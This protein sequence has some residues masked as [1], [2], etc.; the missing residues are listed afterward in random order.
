MNKQGSQNYKLCHIQFFYFLTVLYVD[1][2]ITF[3]TYLTRNKIKSLKFSQSSTMA[4]DHGIHST[5]DFF[6][7]KNAQLDI[8]YLV[9]H[10]SLNLFVW[11]SIFLPL[12]HKRKYPVLRSTCSSNA[13][14]IS[15]NDTH[16]PYC[17]H[18]KYILCIFHIYF[19][20]FNTN[21]HVLIEITDKNVSDKGQRKQ[22]WPNL[23]TIQYNS[24]ELWCQNTTPIIMTDLTTSKTLLC[25][26]FTETTWAI[27]Y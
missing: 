11:Q 17:I 4:M 7:I 5:R 20:N 25:T 24:A 9:I 22:P 14:L 21:A 23:Y 10:P 19:H 18:T 2:E 26:K 8:F 1:G 27:R 15:Q 13:L 12:L 6:Q 3:T 16:L